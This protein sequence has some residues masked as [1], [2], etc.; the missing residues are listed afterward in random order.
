[1]PHCCEWKVLLVGVVLIAGTVAGDEDTV[2][3]GLTYWP[4]LCV[5]TLLSL[6]A[7]VVAGWVWK[8]W[9]KP[10]DAP[11]VP[12]PPVLSITSPTDDS[13]TPVL[14]DFVRVHCGLRH[15]FTERLFCC[16]V[17][18]LVTSRGKKQRR[19]FALTESKKMVVCDMASGH[20]LRGG[21]TDDIST[22]LLDPSQVGLGVV[23]RNSPPMTFYLTSDPRNRPK[24]TAKVFLRLVERLGGA[25]PTSP[26]SSLP[27]LEKK[28][29]LPPG[30]RP[31]GSA[32]SLETLE[33]HEERRVTLK[34]N[35]K[36]GFRVITEDASYVTNVKPGSAAEAAGVLAGSKLLSVNGKAPNAVMFNSVDEDSAVDLHLVLPTFVRKK[37]PGQGG[38]EEQAPVVSPL[39]LSPLP[40]PTADDNPALPPLIQSP[41]SLPTSPAPP[42]PLTQ[43]G[44]AL[45]SKL[46]FRSLAALNR[47]NGERPADRTPVSDFEKEV[48]AAVRRTLGLDVTLDSR[49]DSPCF[50]EKV[51][52]VVQR[53]FFAHT[54]TPQLN[55]LTQNPATSSPTPPPSSP[56][57]PPPPPPP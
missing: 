6:L 4:F 12:P 21:M 50:E 19:V 36:M 55:P 30:L 57:P 18:D 26:V 47:L 56:P 7:G 40:L 49:P 14:P 11:E 32:D 53:G 46:T 51:V 1:M 25:F 54:C 42:P 33:E 34:C 13:G 43:G 5:T 37:G 41:Q 3:L 27:V 9:A 22:V 29:R 35:P 39:A 52:A 10:G 38:G 8:G 24:A 28:G 20:A 23:F 45:S 48:E 16:W 17:I 44:R 2:A 15:L 31:A